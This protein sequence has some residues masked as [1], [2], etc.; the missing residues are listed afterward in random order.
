MNYE[1]KPNC[2]RK[3]NH[4]P[5]FLI[6][7]KRKLPRFFHPLGEKRLARQDFYRCG[8]R[9]ILKIVPPPAPFLKNFLII[10]LISVSLVSNS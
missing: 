5:E 6:S 9:N 3:T 10:E 7:R 8:G 1:L 2:K 4:E